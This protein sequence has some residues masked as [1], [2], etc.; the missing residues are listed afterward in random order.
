[1]VLAVLYEL[2]TINLDIQLLTATDLSEVNFEVEITLRLGI[3]DG[4]CKRAGLGA[5]LSG[6][7]RYR[8]PRGTRAITVS[9]A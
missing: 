5:E 4:N 1:M 8:P 3:G 6:I 2:F 7:Q 9:E